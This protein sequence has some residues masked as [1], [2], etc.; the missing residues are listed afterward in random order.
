[1]TPSEF[2]V[3]LAEDLEHGEATE[4]S[5]HAALLCRDY[6]TIALNTEAD[7]E[8]RMTPRDPDPAATAASAA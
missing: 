1:M 4:D 2:L 7:T 5:Q 8:G 6:A 3:Q